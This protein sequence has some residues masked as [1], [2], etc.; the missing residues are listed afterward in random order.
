MKRI[1]SIAAVMAGTIL[2]FSI[3][4]SCKREPVFVGELP[5]GPVDSTG[6]VDTT[7][8]YVNEHPC[9]P[10]SV[11]FG[12]QVL[13]ILASNCAL[14]G[15][16]DVQSHKE[17][18]ILTS[19]D[20]VKATGGIN[21]NSPTNSKIYKSL[22]ASGGDRMP[23]SP[24]SALTADQKA[25]ILKWIQQGAQN[26]TCE[27]GCDTTNVTYSGSVKPL[28]DLKCKGCHGTTNPSGGIKLTNY[29]EAK[30]VALN[31]E[32]LGTINH[33][34]AYIPMPYP[35]GSAKMPQCEIDVVRIWI[36][37]GAPNN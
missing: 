23:P 3:L 5:T 15:C 20:K 21:L 32:L 36:E 37:D 2:F 16:H 30:I 25:V 9:D 31:G 8:V 29:D 14:S 13:P 17:G 34:S 10:D 22:N 11:Y 18:V 27:S 4:F 33:E 19:F 12:A 1:Q 26:L 35:A 24:Y 7:P 6:I 28:L